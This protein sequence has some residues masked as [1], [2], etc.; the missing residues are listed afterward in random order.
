MTEKIRIALFSVCFLAAGVSGM[1]ISAKAAGI[2]NESQASARAQEKIPGATVTDVDRDHEQGVV[3]YDVDLVKGNKKYEIT[4]RASD[5]KIVAYGWEK[6]SVGA[7]RNK[8]VI[9]ES[10]CRSLAAGK[11]KNGTILSVVHKYD[12]GIEYYKVKMTDANK[13]Y[14]MEFHAR[15]GALIDYEW[16]YTIMP[17]GGNNNNG[18][19]NNGTNNGNNNNGYIGLNKAKQI[20]KDKVPGAVV[21]KA[22]FDMDDGVPVYEIELVKGRYEYDVKIHAQTGNILEWDQDYDD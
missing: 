14:K 13:T 9:S 10:K 6:I 19:N 21:V 8:P 12:D 7:S 11:V 5:A 3:V 20:A 17:G 4:Y 22:E 1:T 18:N 16:K 15:T 2:S